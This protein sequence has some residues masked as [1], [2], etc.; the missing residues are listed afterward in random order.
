MDRFHLWALI[1]LILFAFLLA[2]GILIEN[3]SAGSEPL[4]P[5]QSERVKKNNKNENK[6]KKY[7]PWLHVLFAILLL[8]FCLREL[9]GLGLLMVSGP[10][11]VS[12]V[13]TEI[14]KSSGRGKS[15]RNKVHIGE[16]TVHY[17]LPNGIKKGEVYTIQYTPLTLRPI[18]VKKL[19]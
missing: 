6:N 19:R 9:A 13:V 3:L 11:Q 16:I 14:E 2:I 10:K 5:P 18:G 7:P 1:I 4:Q 17:I 8:S 15:F 12:G